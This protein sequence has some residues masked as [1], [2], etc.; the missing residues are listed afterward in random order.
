MFRDRI[1][2]FSSVVAVFLLL[3]LG[4]NELYAGGGQ[5]YP[6]GAEAFMIGA[7]P[8][9]GLVMVNY[10][11]YGHADSSKDNQGRDNDLFDNAD[12]YGDIVRFIWISK[13]RILGAQYGQHL[14]FGVLG[15]DIDFNTAVGSELKSSYSDFNLLY[16]VY[17]PMLLGWHLMDG[18][19]HVAASLCDIYIPLY[20]E[21][22]G[23]VASVG[24]N[25]WTFEP[26]LAFTYM[27]TPITEL[28]MKFMYDFNTKQQDYEPGPPARVDRIPGQ[29]FHFDFNLAVAVTENLKIGINGYYY[30]Q[31]TDDDYDSIR[32]SDAVPAAAY[33]S[34]KAALD[35]EERHI[36]R[37]FALGPGIM[38]RN[39][40]FM[41]TL[42]Y[43]EEIEVRNKADMRQ[44]WFKL[45]YIF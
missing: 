31:T 34:I 8:P 40:N 15:T 29:E 33:P 18:K 20:N 45:I 11:Y 32:Y 9:P 13:Q 39:R 24:R 41:A 4:C 27:P 22:K 16:A 2:I 28:S 30:Q 7:M 23:N 35:R 1:S 37:A 25:F 17:S 36:T 12:I 14:F 26:V 44:V 43:Q 19:L 38:Y 21:D 6:N 42:R 10:A 3:L 5:Q